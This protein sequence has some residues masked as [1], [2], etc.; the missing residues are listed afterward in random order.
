MAIAVA[1]VAAAM[2]IAIGIVAVT[3]EATTRGAFRTGI[4]EFIVIRLD[5]A[6]KL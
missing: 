4:F 1:T 5:G 3:L 2:G 6:E